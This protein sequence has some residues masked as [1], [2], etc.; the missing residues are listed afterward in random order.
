MLEEYGPKIKYTKGPDNEATDALIR[1]PLIK[2]DV[3]ESDITRE[4]LAEIYGV[5]QL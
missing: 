5:D 2:S 1:L 3:T 4:H